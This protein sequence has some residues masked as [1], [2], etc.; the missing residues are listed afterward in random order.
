[1]TIKA[2]TLRQARN[3]PPDEPWVWLS[4]EMLESEAWRSLSRAS[5]L[6]IDR[7]ILE[8]MAHA[9]T[10]N[11]SLAVTYSD[12][13]K[14][15]IRRQSLKGAITDAV[16]KGLLIITVK[17]RPSTG[18]DRWP[19]R[20][21]LGWLPMYDGTAPSNRWKQW[22]KDRPN[23]PRPT[24]DIE[25]STGTGT[26]ENGRNTGSLGAKMSLGPKCETAT[27]EMPQTLN[28]QGAKSAPGKKQRNVPSLRQACKIAGDP[29]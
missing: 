3:R 21:A 7:V 8:H 11:G 19:T 5:R 23:H 14:F 26:R 12:F 25:S 13:T 16:T 1:M 15:G 20:Y 22:T 18:D 24:R 4:R 17:G 27:R 9:G 29:G 6:V 2:K 10:M 28:F